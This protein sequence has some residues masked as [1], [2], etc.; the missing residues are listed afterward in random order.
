MSVRG[1]KYVGVWAPKEGVVAK[2]EVFRRIERRMSGKI[3]MVRPESG[4][5]FRH[6]TIAAD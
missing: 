2:A 5:Q 4:R 3:M 6:P 1:Y